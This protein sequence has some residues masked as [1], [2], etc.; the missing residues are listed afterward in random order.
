[1]VE[2]GTETAALVLHADFLKV[3]QTRCPDWRIGAKSTLAHLQSFP[4]TPI[5]Y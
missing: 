2:P 1:V 4:K 3:F 5:K